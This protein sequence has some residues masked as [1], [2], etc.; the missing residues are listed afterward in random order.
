M[1][2]QIQN[3]NL[4]DI[5]KRKKKMA[6][7]HTQYDPNSIEK[8]AEKELDSFTDGA[9]DP[10]KPL[11]KALTLKE[12]DNGMLMTTVI[13]EQYRTLAVDMSRKLQ[14]EYDCQNVSEKATCELVTVNFVR[15][16]EIQR[17][18]NNVLGLGTTTQN[19]NQYMAVLS[20]EL[21]RANRHYQ[22]ILQ[23]LRL[24]K[25]SPLQITVKAQTAVIGQNQ[26]VQ[27]NNNHE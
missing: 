6:G 22:S 11:F 3:A 7:L 16:L 4:T 8:L 15:V 19:L 17:K 24:M 1:T 27:T 13:P 2:P 18:L 20:K 9:I 5:E 25:Q 26:L 10:A 23:T 21:D 12:F 14:K